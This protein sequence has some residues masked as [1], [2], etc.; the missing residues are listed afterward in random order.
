MRVSTLA[1]V[2]RADGT[3]AR[4]RVCRGCVRRAV[5][6]VPYVT[7]VT[8]GVAPVEAER[9]EA[10]EVVKA[11]SSKLRRLASAYNGSQPARSSGLEQAAD[12]LDAGD[13]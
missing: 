5:V 10:K 6:I 7:H 11:A 3:L 1:Q 9:R 13:F 8:K 12:I 2:A 4:G